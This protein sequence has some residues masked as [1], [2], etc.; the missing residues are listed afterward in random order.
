MSASQHVAPIGYP[1]T[2]R[3]FGLAIV[4][5]GGM[6]LMAVL[7][8]TVINLALAP[9]QAELN[10]SDA[11]RNWVV[12]SY[13]LAFGGLM[14]LGGRMGDSFGRKRMFLTGVALFTLASAVCGLAQNEAML[15]GARIVQGA[16]AAV[17]SPTAFALVATTFAPG[18][19]RNQ[20]IAIYAAM[21]G[22]GSFSGLIIGGALT[23]VSWRWIFLINVPIGLAILVV[24]ARALVETAAERTA[25]D[26]PGAVLATLGSTAVVF[27]IVEG[28]ERGWTDAVTVASVLIGLALLG[29][30][31]VV[32]RRA[33]NPL[34]PFELFRDR[35]RVA[36][37]A[38]IFFS[39]GALFAMT[40]IVAVF[41][42]DVLGYSPLHAGI[43]FI[44]FG[45]G[46]A[47]AAVTSS[48]LAPRVA[49]RWIVFTGA[50][51]TVGYLIFA[52]RIDV[53]ASYWSD[54]FLPIGGI[55]FGV[56]LAVIALPL[57]AIAQVRAEN[58]GPLTAI[59]LV[60][61]NLGGPLGLAVVSAM[62]AAKT[63]SLGGVTGSAVSMTEEQVRVLGEGYTFGLLGC[64]GLAAV[65]AVSA[66][67]IRYSAAD[68][69]SAK[70]AQE[71]A[72]G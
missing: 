72:R 38:A 11:G 56:G 69:A 64:A 52:S 24:G 34:L 39:G 17:A 42:Q 41:V 4:A 10:L 37:F 55:G 5:L 12:S 61:Q 33:S 49:P 9:L 44:P 23:E 32:E 48:W 20:A 45:G 7:D 53:D 50:V 27:G 54:L 26:V 40:V 58:I 62:A 18:P 3:A 28:P 60:A 63:M 68:V 22:V 51:L 66:L 47:L 21:T 31:L 16:G 36:T 15:V 14:L 8:G 25:L 65:A 71:A 2:T 19:V 13:V 1:V 6:Q 70:A 30:F 67:F 46:M 43:S 57:C 59:S 35:D 29:A